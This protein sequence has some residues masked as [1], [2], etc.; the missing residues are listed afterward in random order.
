LIG[1]EGGK[2][3]A[4]DDNVAPVITGIKVLNESDK[5]FRPGLI[6]ME[7]D[8]VEEG[9][10]VNQIWADFGGISSYG[11]SG[12]EDT[13]GNNY[14]GYSGK[15]IIQFPVSE[16]QALGK[17]TFGGIT[18]SDKFGNTSSYNLATLNKPVIEVVDEFDYN[19]M[20]GLGNSTLVTQ[21]ENMPESSAA[22]L[23]MDSSGY[24]SRGKYYGPQNILAKACLDAIK[25]KDKTIVAHK[26]GLQWVINGRDIKRATK[27]IRLDVSYG[28][29]WRG[30]YER[31]PFAPGAYSEVISDI[32]VQNL[33][34]LSPLEN[35]ASLNRIEELRAYAVNEDFSKIEFYPNG[36]LP[37]KAQVRF[38][39]DILYEKGMTGIPTLYYY[40]GKELTAEKS[41]FD[42]NFDGND[43]WCYVDI[44]HNSTFAVSPTS[45]L[46]FSCF[47]KFYSDNGGKVASRKVKSGSKIGVL[48]NPK[49]TGYNFAG[50]F[51]TRKG[52]TKIN[53]SRI[54]NAK[55]TFYAH[56]TPKKF[57][58]KF[59]AGKGKVSPKSKKIT[60]GKA[61]GK[62][63]TPKRKGY[64]FKGWYVG[65]KKITSKTWTLKAKNVTATA[66]WKK[67]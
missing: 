67:K 43:K 1:T 41:G 42:L 62:L 18:I 2:A 64:K 39:S 60:Y 36:E 8:I 26:G 25:G 12:G 6:R 32:T 7:L 59:S 54:I 37:G 3:Y 23:S 33:E 21:L 51:T 13:A 35:Y 31:N 47:V 16:I 65:S 55:A 58:L 53:A 15:V 61:Y 50:W 27:D 40:N 10:G 34:S 4:E 22:K 66:K 63:P 38:K 44:E 17:Y 29:V 9:S 30:T 11:W 45:K 56:W 28:V 19:F 20:T 52:G 46:T 57:T 49:R 5:V 14:K 48:P 24:W